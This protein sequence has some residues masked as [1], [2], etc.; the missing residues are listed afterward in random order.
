MPLDNA[1]DGTVRVFPYRVF[2]DLR[3]CLARRMRLVQKVFRVRS[4]FFGSGWLGQFQTGDH[5][6]E[7]DCPGCHAVGRHPRFRRP[8]GRSRGRHHL[9]IRRQLHVHHAQVAGGHRQAAERHFAADERFAEQPVDAER[10]GRHSAGSWREGAGHQPGGP[11]SRHHGH[12]Q[13]QRPGCSRDLLQQGSRPESH[14]FLRQGLLHRYRPGA[15][16]RDPG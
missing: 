14:R 12:R 6:N 5:D 7:E 11:R 15:V 8:G 16:R 10:P 4:V 1:A 9:Q 13:G 3:G 2:P